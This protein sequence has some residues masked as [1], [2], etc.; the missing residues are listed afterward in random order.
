MHLRVIEFEDMILM[1][2]IT[3]FHQISTLQLDN[4]H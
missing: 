4:I 1:I 2:L 3:E